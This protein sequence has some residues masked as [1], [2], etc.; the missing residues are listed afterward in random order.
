[1]NEGNLAFGFACEA[2]VDERK[3]LGGYFRCGKF[4]LNMP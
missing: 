4:C 2:T 3:R 1:M